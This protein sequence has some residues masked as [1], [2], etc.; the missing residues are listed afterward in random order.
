MPEGPLRIVSY[1]V[2]YFG[3]ALRGLASTRT[4]L[5]R[6]AQQLTSLTPLADVICLQEV[7]TRSLM[8]M[9]SRSSGGC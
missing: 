3:H 1:N 6:I 7:E 9:T 2:R 4:S 5:E 8:S